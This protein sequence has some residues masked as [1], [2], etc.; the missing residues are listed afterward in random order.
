MKKVVIKKYHFTDV[1]PIIFKQTNFTLFAIIS[2]L[3]EVEGQ[4]PEVIE[5]WFDEP[6]AR[7]SVLV[8]NDPWDN[9]K[10]KAIVDYQWVDEQ[11]FDENGDYID[12]RIIAEPTNISWSECQL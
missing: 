2:K 7:C 10:L 4:Q 11:E 8:M 12:S 1:D 9:N 5:H 6:E 3:A